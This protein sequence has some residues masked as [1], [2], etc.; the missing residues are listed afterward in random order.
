[1]GVA[2]DDD[3]GLRT[4]LRRFDFPAEY[5]QSA[6]RLSVRFHPLRTLRPAVYFA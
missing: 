6:S 3:E 5:N 2:G 4:S 1:V